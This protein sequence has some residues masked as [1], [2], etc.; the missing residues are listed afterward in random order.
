MENENENDHNHSGGEGHHGAH[1]DMGCSCDLGCAISIAA[2]V[3]VLLG[4]G[5]V[6]EEV[7]L[8]MLDVASWVDKGRSV[9]VLLDG[10]GM[11]RAE[12]NP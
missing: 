8:C 7:G 4:E 3:G 11:P 9:P 1:H 12:A 5:L 6:V 2:L 10:G